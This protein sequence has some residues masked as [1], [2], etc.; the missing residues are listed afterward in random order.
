MPPAQ[1]AFLRSVSVHSWVS[2]KRLEEGRFICSLAT[3]GTVSLTRA[4][5]SMLLEGIDWTST[6]AKERICSSQ[7]Q[8]AA[9]RH[10]VSLAQ[11]RRRVHA[12]RVGSGGQRSRF[13]PQPEDQ[14]IPDS[15]GSLPDPGRIEK[16]I[17]SPR[18]RDY[19][20]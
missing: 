9:G 17:R 8:L 2:Y 10:R 3:E 18:R 12:T 5:L 20:G 4:Q 7:A 16:S 19:T 15:S 6:D 1:D 13:H 14:P 11:H